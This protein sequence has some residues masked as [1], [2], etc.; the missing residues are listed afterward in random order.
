[1]SDISNIPDASSTYLEIILLLNPAEKNSFRTGLMLFRS[2][3]DKSIVCLKK[4]QLLNSEAL[5]KEIRS[6]HWSTAEKVMNMMGT[7]FGILTGITV[8]SSGGMI[9][10]IA[11][12]SGGALMLGSHIME[13]TGGWK[14]VE[15]HLEGDPQKKSEK[16]RI[17]QIGATALSM[18]LMGAPLLLNSSLV[19]TASNALSKSVGS[20]IIGG[21]A[22]CTL[23]Q[24]K[25][26]QDYL[27][28]LSDKEAN[29]IPLE[30]SRFQKKELLSSLLTSS[31][32]K[33]KEMHETY[34][35]ITDKVSEDILSIN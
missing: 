4:V 25:S 31:N 6:K 17:Y 8:A 22:V 16:S 2:A 12:I 24:G 19:S 15:E 21:D 3:Q 30:H 18:I 9:A 27:M 32:Q 34:F 33:T 5:E 11:M 7:S 35:F 23:G 29:Q 1:M 10:G 20:L 13:I 28:T 26:K 14:K